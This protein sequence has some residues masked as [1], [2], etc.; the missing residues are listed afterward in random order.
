MK[1]PLLIS[2]FPPVVGLQ[3][4][5]NT[6]YNFDWTNGYKE[7]EMNYSK[8][9][10]MK[11]KSCDRQLES[12]TDLE[13]R[14]QK[15]NHKTHPSFV[16][17]SRNIC[18]LLTHFSRESTPGVGR[19]QFSLDVLQRSDQRRGGGE[20]RLALDSVLLKGSLCN[21]CSIHRVASS[22]QSHQN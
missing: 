4:N 7:S 13:T 12:R 16:L 17:A 8:R 2:R 3:K 19:K 1:K 5:K 18:W 14:C 9:E 11:S 6:M 21:F 20:E 22:A 10:Q 15:G